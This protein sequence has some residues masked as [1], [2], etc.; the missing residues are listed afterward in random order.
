MIRVVCLWCYRRTPD[1]GTGLRLAE[2]F[3]VP[4]SPESCRPTGPP[5]VVALGPPSDDE[6]WNG[7][8]EQLSSRQVQLHP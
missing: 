4:D 1:G 3:S 6:K 7:R 8:A 2:L 5:S